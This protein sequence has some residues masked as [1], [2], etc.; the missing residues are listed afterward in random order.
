MKLWPKSSKDKNEPGKTGRIYVT[1]KDVSGNGDS[2]VYFVNEKRGIRKMLVDTQ[3]NIQNFPGIVKEDFWL[4]RVSSNTLLPRIR[5]SSRFEERENKWIMLWTIQPDGDYWRDDSGFGGEKEVEIVLYTYVDMN[6]EFTGPFRIYSFG[7]AC[8]SLDRFEHAHRERYSEA[9][10]ALQTGEGRMNLEILF[11]RLLGMSIPAGGTS[12]GEYYSIN[13]RVAADYWAHPVLSRHLLEATNALLQ[14]DVPISQRI[15]YEGQRIV[16][17][18][19]TLFD[20]V[21]GEPV[22]RE[23][24]DKHFD[25][26]PEKLTAWLL[27]MLAKST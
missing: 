1:Q 4:K 27:S 2:S 24:L 8:Y 14:L 26:E 6:G 5:Y 13:K 22:F 17:S 23:V 20:A 18:C 16:Q 12:W 3:G 11:P 9:L 19:M 15:G 25:G 7:I 10:R 21:T